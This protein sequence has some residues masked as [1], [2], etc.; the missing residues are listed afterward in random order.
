MSMLIL[1]LILLIIAFLLLKLKKTQRQSSTPSWKYH[2]QEYDKQEY[3]LSDKGDDIIRHAP[4]PD[5]DRGFA[6]L[7]E[8]EIVGKK[9]ATNR[10]NTRYIR[11]KDE[12]TARAY[13]IQIEG[14]MEPLSISVAP[15]RPAYELDYGLTVPD[16]AS[17]WDCQMFEWSVVAKDTQHIPAGFMEY[18]TDMGIPMSWLSGRNRAADA[19]FERCDLREKLALYAYAVH[20]SIQGRIPGNIQKDPHKEQ[21]DKFASSALLDKK[22]CESIEKRPGSDMWQPSTRTIAYQ[23]A[24]KFLCGNY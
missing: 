24:V 20:C 6:N 15:F 23:F 1:C 22:V 2:Q 13:A 10:K 16:G 7:T 21:Y 12:D 3:I 18:L 19:A 11:C 8:F 17:Y 14:L 5:A 9:K 4:K